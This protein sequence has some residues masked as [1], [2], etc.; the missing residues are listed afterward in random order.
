VCVSQTP[1]RRRGGEK[2]AELCAATGAEPS[3]VGPTGVTAGLARAV[4][5]GLLAALRGGVVGCAATASR[6]QASSSR[7]A[8]AQTASHHPGSWTLLVGEG[9]TCNCAV[10]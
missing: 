9:G 7:S 6:Q 5:V 2:D 3:R 1:P 4:I 10:S 8:C